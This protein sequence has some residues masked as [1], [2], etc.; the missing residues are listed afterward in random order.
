[1]PQSSAASQ[2]KRVADTNCCALDTVFVLSCLFLVVSGV[3]SAIIAWFDPTA[4]NPRWAAGSERLRNAVVPVCHQ[5]AAHPFIH[6]K[7]A[8]RLVQ[9]S[10]ALMAAIES[11]FPAHMAAGAISIVTPVTLLAFA[12]CARGTSAISTRAAVVL[13]M[14]SLFSAIIAGLALLS[15]S[16]VVWTREWEASA[17]PEPCRQNLTAALASLI[18]GPNASA[19]PTEWTMR[20][21][22]MELHRQFSSGQLEPPRLDELL[23]C[24]FP[25]DGM[26]VAATA[27]GALAV[28]G[29]IAAT[30]TEPPAQHCISCARKRHLS[31]KAA[32]SQSGHRSSATGGGRAHVSS[33]DDDTDTDS[34]AKARGARTSLLGFA[35]R[36]PPTCTYVSCVTP[37]RVAMLAAIIHTTVSPSTYF[38]S[39]VGAEAPS[40]GSS[41]PLTL[42]RS[43]LAYFVLA[44]LAWS[45]AARPSSR[46]ATLATVCGCSTA[47]SQM[48]SRSHQTIMTP[49]LSSIHAAL[50][51]GGASQPALAAKATRTQL[52]ESGETLRAFTGYISHSTRVPLNNSLGAARAVLDDVLTLE[53]SLQRGAGSLRP[54]W[55]RGRDLLGPVRSMFEGGGTSLGSS[56][57]G[58]KDLDIIDAVSMAGVD[59]FVDHARLTQICANFASNS[60]KF[61]AGRP[62]RLVV[63]LQRRKP[64]GATR[65]PK[66]AAPGY[67]PAFG[68]L[69][70]GRPVERSRP[71]EAPRY[72]RASIVPNT[73]ADAGPPGQEPTRIP[74][75]ALVVPALN[76]LVREVGRRSLAMVPPSSWEASSERDNTTGGP[77]ASGSATSLGH[78]AFG[79][80]M[81]AGSSAVHAGSP[82]SGSRWQPMVLVVQAV[83]QGVG[84]EE[85]DR[86]NLFR[87]FAQVDAG[88]GTKGVGT[89]L[90]LAVCAALAHAM[91][92][93]VGH[94]PNTVAFGA[95]GLDEG[96]HAPPTRR[97]DEDESAPTTR[98]HQG[99]RGHSGV[100]LS[101]NEGGSSARS[102][103]MD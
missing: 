40:Q 66:L 19:W 83:D 8:D 29:V 39:L 98:R 1:M 47:S 99:T 75:P 93:T 27:L 70:Y 81:R 91:G 96:A 61:G 16:A 6:P 49:K 89:G 69:R 5:L 80:S 103:A 86:V 58:A 21:T 90:G 32:R 88:V 2:R 31:G 9:Y 15:G 73:V 87:A 56:A 17:L 36:L 11:L 59:V 20:S 63:H 7:V 41:Y 65:A 53:S 45:R 37:S 71:A 28:A 60:I 67:A 101:S 62:A 35:S 102:D 43:G 84:V 74:L 18:A 64:G 34:V 12:C 25:A 54:T 76:E 4:Y 72:T 57:A 51:P 78:S 44:F 22:P 46:V 38:P 3:A 50:A 24:L 14:S 94:A 97:A 26:A 23:A 95:A 85:A 42:V 68:S 48:E 82:T 79:G 77:Q 30:P 55:V 13:G 10:A 33:D 92:G 52:Q 100:P